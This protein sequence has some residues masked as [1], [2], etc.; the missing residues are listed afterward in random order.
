MNHYTMFVLT[1]P[2]REY[3]ARALTESVFKHAAVKPEYIIVCSRQSIPTYGW[4]PQVRVITGVKDIKQ[5]LLSTGLSKD[6]WDRIIDG[7]IDGG[8][9]FIKYAFPRLCMETPCLVSDDDVIFRGPCIELFESTADF[10]F[11]DDPQ[12][13]Y[14]ENSVKLFF[15]NKWVKNFPTCFVCAGF[16]LANQFFVSHDVVNKV[17]MAAQTHRD[18]QSA[19]GMESMLGTTEVLLPPKYI[20]GGYVRRRIPNASIVHAQHAELIHMQSGLAYLRNQV[21]FLA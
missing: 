16:Y 19:V 15:E 17:I 14:G 13:Y 3:L 18:E 9:M 1:T 7:S 2:A 8:D 11:M 21:P 5:L 4:H 12:G 10:T 6:A 20:H